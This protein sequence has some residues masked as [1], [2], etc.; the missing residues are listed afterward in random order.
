[1]PKSIRAVFHHPLTAT[2]EARIATLI[3]EGTEHGY[4]VAKIA[5][6]IRTIVLVKRNT[7]PR[8]TA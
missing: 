2:D 8:G 3:A 7:P 5:N 6:G 1:M 4:A